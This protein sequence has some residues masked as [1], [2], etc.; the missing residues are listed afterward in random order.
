MKYYDFLLAIQE[1]VKKR[2]GENYTINL[3]RIFKNNGTEQDGLV[4]FRKGDDIAPNIYM[5]DYYDSY[6]NGMSVELV[7]EEVIHRYK[8][9]ILDNRYSK[10]DLA[11]EFDSVKEKIIYRLV[12]YEK[13]RQLLSNAPHICFLDLAITFHIVVNTD[14]KQM[15]TIRIT[16]D[17]S[18][19]WG[20][21]TTELFSLAQKNTPKKMPVCIRSMDE[22]IYDILKREREQL[23]CEQGYDWEDDLV[24]IID[25]MER[26]PRTA[27]YVLTN[28]IGVNGATTLLYENVM[29]QFANE[30]QSDFYILPS[31]IHELILVPFQSEMGK[32]S[33]ENIVSEVNQTQVAYN[34]ILSDRVYLYQRATNTLTY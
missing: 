4:I 16:N 18:E 28:N 10:F 23:A 24:Q 5:N 6:K 31:S 32:E 15:A 1:Y 21:N 34:E 30:I 8:E 33:L 2:L 22:V 7:A 11:F 27:I 3:N 12:N 19:Q 26:E 25:D 13:N 9:E 20:T 17:L 14:K 29:D